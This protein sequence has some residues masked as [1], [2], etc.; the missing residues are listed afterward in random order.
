LAQS[1]IDYSA[2]K[3]IVQVFM[4][5]VQYLLDEE[6]KLPAKPVSLKKTSIENYSSI[7]QKVTKTISYAK[8]SSSSFSSKMGLEVGVKMTATYGVPAVSSVSAQLSTKVS[9]SMTTGETKTTTETDSTAVSVTV[10]ACSK[11]HATVSGNEYTSNIPYEATIRK[12]YYDGDEATGKI[13]GIYTGVGVSEV[14]VKYGKTIPLPPST[15]SAQPQS[16][17]QQ[18]SPTM[19]QAA[20]GN[21]GIMMSSSNNDIIDKYYEEKIEE[22][23]N[24]TELLTKLLTK[25]L[26]EEDIKIAI[27]KHKA[28]DL[29]VDLPDAEEI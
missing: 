18:S 6:E 11:M 28:E 23:K 24:T 7:A 1:A 8:S 13:S 10:P 2:E 29:G 4:N 16:A 5:N 20:P 9:M 12:I 3:P 22:T 19:T 21:V 17:P 26:Y 25:Q 27:Y 15:C 14:S